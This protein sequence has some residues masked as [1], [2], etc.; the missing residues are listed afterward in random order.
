MKRGRKKQR[1]RGYADKVR[2]KLNGRS[3]DPRWMWWTVNERG[4]VAGGLDQGE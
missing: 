2:L 4:V 3:R 1:R